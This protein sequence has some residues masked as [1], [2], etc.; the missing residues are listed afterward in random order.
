M[1]KDVPH[2]FQTRGFQT[3]G[4]V[5]NDQ[6][7]WIGHCRPLLSIGFG[8]ISPGPGCDLIDLHDITISSRRRLKP[9]RWQERLFALPG[10]V[11]TSLFFEPSLDR[12]QP[13]L[14][15]FRLDT[16]FNM[17][18]RI[19]DFRRIEYGRMIG[20]GGAFGNQHRVR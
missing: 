19:D 15:A 20:D 9:S 5:N 8:N 3:I 11:Q 18:R 13:E 14:M 12:K 10:L 2:L 1:V 7:G 17:S 4:L 6:I 16:V